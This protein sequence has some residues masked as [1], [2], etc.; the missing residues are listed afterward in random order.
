MLKCVVDNVSCSSFE[1]TVFETSLMFASH[2]S[3]KFDWI[4]STVG[5]KDEWYYLKSLSIFLNN[6][7]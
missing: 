7:S 6:L 1:T 4:K 2:F 3:D 5:C